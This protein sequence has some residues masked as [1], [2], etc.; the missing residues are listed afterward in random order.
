MT[1]SRGFAGHLWTWVQAVVLVYLIAF[2]V[3]LLGSVVTVFVRGAIEVLS[4]VA[5][6]IR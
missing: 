4:W 5:T 2:A 3:V 6:L 1:R